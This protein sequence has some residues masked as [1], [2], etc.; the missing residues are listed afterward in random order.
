MTLPA[1]YNC[2]YKEIHKWEISSF[3]KKKKKRINKW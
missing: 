2:V 3:S 1:K